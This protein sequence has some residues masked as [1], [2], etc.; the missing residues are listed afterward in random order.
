MDFISNL[1]AIPIGFVMRLFYTIIPNYAI[2][3]LLITI[4][5]RLFM[6][7]STLK[8]QKSG[9]KLARV[10]PKIREIQETYKNNREK[11]NQEI[12]KVYAEEGYNPMSGCLPLLITWPIFFGLI[13]VIY[14]PLTFLL[15]L[16][17]NLIT[18][19]SAAAEG[20]VMNSPAGL[21]RMLELYVVR[22]QD[23]SFI[24]QFFPN[25]TGLNLRLFG[26]D[27]S[28]TPD[29]SHFS[30]LWLIPLLAG[31]S[32][33]L[34]FLITQKTTGQKSGMAMGIV[35]PLISVW[36]TFSFPAAVGLYWFYSALVAGVQ[37]LLIRKFYNPSA[38]EAKSLLNAAKRRSQKFT[39]Q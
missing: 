2:V 7:P 1:L 36:M 31:V 11:M 16:N 39:G 4:V 3:L 14:R 10:Q 15:G 9:A 30:A 21:S 25:G 20:V 38:S 18:Q 29:L 37:S 5:T 8:Q 24:T 6:I 17:S 13:G 19:A 23:R 22:F 34:M 26:L 27:L 32:Q 33:L 28:Q 12:Q 35:F